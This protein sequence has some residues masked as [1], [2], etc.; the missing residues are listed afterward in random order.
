MIMLVLANAY[1][2]CLTSFMAAQKF[3]TLPKSLGDFVAM[4]RYKISMEKNTL[5]TGLF[6]VECKLFEL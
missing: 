3:E 2:G 1:S 4:K 5:L 6:L